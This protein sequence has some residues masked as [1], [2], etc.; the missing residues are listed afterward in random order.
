MHSHDRPIAYFI[1]DLL[2][3]INKVKGYSSGIITIEDLLKQESTTEL[4]IHQLEIIGESVRH[5]LNCEESAHLIPEYWRSIVNFRNVISHE[6]FGINYKEVL[7]IIQ[8]Y[9]PQLEEE[10]LFLSQNIKIKPDLSQALKATEK[11]LSKWNKQESLNILK[12]I[13]QQLKDNS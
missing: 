12:Y 3:S 13:A 10:T 8:T 4:I 5:I 6:Y 11:E 2:I 7:K 1:V 9:I